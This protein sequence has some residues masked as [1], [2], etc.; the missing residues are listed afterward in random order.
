[1]QEYRKGD[2]LTGQLKAE[3]IKVLQEFV[4]GFQEVLASC[5]LSVW[6]AD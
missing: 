5:F 2:L 6:D 1:M 4:K 3:C